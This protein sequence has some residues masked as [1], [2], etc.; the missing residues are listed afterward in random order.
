VMHFRKR[1]ILILPAMIAHQ[2]SLAM[3][4]SDLTS[5]YPLS[6]AEANKLTIL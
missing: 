5:H 4:V 3:L 2:G 1:Y 6:E